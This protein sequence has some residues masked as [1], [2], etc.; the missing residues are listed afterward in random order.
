MIR[1]FSDSTS[2]LSD[3]LIRKYDITVLPL[4]IILGEKEYKDREDISPAE[5]FSWSDKNKTTPIRPLLP[6]RTY[7]RG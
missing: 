2:D 3:E 6:S 7:S 4:F 1:I 5:I